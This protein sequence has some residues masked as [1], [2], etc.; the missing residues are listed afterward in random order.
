MIQVLHRYISIS[1]AVVLLTGG[2]MG[3]SP[4]SSVTTA[5]AVVVGA[6]ESQKKRD[7]WKKYAEKGDVYAQWELANSYCCNRLEGSLNPVE[8]YYWFCTAAK[9]GDAKSQVEMARF[10]EGERKLNG[11]EIVISRSQ[12]F[13]WYTLAARRVSS[14]GI[15]GKRR[16]KRD[17]TLQELSLALWW[18]DRD[19]D[20]FPCIISETKIPDANIEGHNRE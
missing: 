13:M 1:I 14:D 16:L 19:I 3:C 20:Q 17:M 8:A 18:L 4:L 9:N 11:G 5:A 7:K 15:K 2:L 6:Y 10:L 12:S